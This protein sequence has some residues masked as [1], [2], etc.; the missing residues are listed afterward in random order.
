MPGLFCSKYVALAHA[1]NSPILRILTSNINQVTSIASFLAVLS[2]LRAPHTL[3]N[4][5]PRCSLAEVAIGTSLC[6]KKP[7]QGRGL[8][9]GI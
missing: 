1:P 9:A 2:T 4:K 5:D 8:K 3:L 6:K 7:R